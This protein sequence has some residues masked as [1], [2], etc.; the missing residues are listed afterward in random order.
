MRYLSFYRS[1]KT[2][3]RYRSHPSWYILESNNDWL[4]SYHSDLC[5]QYVNYYLSLGL[6]SSPCIHSCVLSFT[7]KPFKHSI[8]S[9]LSPIYTH[10]NSMTSQEEVQKFYWSARPCIITLC[11]TTSQVFSFILCHSSP[12]LIS[13]SFEAMLCLSHRLFPPSG[14]LFPLFICIAPTYSSL[15][16]ITI[17]QGNL[18]WLAD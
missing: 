13:L 8:Y 6:H 12:C 5:P 9:C 4:S 10:E 17:S 7:M 3:H 2:F 14:M 18:P 15:N 16:L 11:L 1:H